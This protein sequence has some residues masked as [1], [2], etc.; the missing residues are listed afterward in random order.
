MVL[1]YLST[2]FFKTGFMQVFKFAIRFNAFVLAGKSLRIE[3]LIQIEFGSDWEMV[4]WLLL[5]SKF[6][7]SNRFEVNFNTIFEEEAFIS[8]ESEEIV[9]VD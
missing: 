9:L 7:G 3:L 1:G 2:K 6:Q 5:M 4:K 8:L